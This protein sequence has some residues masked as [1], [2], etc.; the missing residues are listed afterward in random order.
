[1]NTG[2]NILRKRKFNSFIDYIKPEIKII[3][4][5]IISIL[6]FFTSG[7]SNYFEGNYT[8]FYNYETYSLIILLGFIFVFSIAGKVNIKYYWKSFLYILFI[9]PV[10]FLFNYLVMMEGKPLSES[11]AYTLFLTIDIC[12]RLYILFFISSILILSSTELE[13]ASAIEL[14]ITPLKYIKIPTKEISLIISLGLRYIPILI[15]DSKIIL[16]AQAT[17]GNDF[18]TGNIFIKIKS[19]VNLLNPLIISAFYKASE[20]SN[21]MY[22]R[23]FRLKQKRKIYRENKKIDLVDFFS[24][25]YFLNLFIFIILI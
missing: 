6:V 12:L 18:E 13:I 2:F 17:R 24:M 23:G 20:T 22:V 25:I 9:F 7:I 1:M 19:F 14:L 5:F 16:E 21:A 10:L 15:L 3:S 4:F 8:I 11:L